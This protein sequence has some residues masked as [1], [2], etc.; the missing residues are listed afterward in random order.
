MIKMKVNMEAYLN[1]IN[2]IFLEKVEITNKTNSIFLLKNNFIRVEINPK[3]YKW[4]K[5]M[6]KLH[7]RT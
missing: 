4:R 6:Q 3:S 2:K 7:Q 1:K 5:T